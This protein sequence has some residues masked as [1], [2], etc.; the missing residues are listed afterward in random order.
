MDLYNYI[1]MVPIRPDLYLHFGIISAA[2]IVF[3]IYQ[4]IIAA[5]LQEVLFLIFVAR[6]LFIFTLVTWM[7]FWYQSACN[8]I[9]REV[10]KR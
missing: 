5:E 10:Y 9:K 7:V 3:N 6:N 4:A 1:P 8:Y 2:V